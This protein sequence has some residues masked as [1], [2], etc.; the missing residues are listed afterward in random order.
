MSVKNYLSLLSTLLLIFLLA[1][2]SNDKAE[3]PA[4]SGSPEASASASDASME[5]IPLHGKILETF[6]SGGYTYVRLDSGAKESWAAMPPTPVTVGEEVTL[7]GVMMMP[8]FHSTTLN[9]TFDEIFFASGLLEPGEAEAAGMN[10]ESAPAASPGGWTGAIQS[11]GATA[12]P[13][14]ETQPQAVP[15]EQIKVEKA[16]GPNSYTVSELFARSA[17]LD[18]KPVMLKAQVVKIA[19]NIMDKNW[20]HLQDGSGDPKQNNFDLV[21]TT[22]TVLQ[23]NDIVTVEGKLTIDKNV[24]SIHKYPILLDDATITK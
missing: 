1:A 21:A 3:A 20:I 6:D 19:N 16:S 9:R 4:A 17:E 5:P 24:G 2:C 23:I 18:G 8:N 15:F 10:Q 11:T 14:A 13:Q 22:A 7:A 12:S